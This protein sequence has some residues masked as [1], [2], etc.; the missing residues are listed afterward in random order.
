MNLISKIILKM[1]QPKCL[2]FLPSIDPKEV[3]DLLNKGFFDRS[4]ENIENKAK[5]PL[6]NAESKVNKTYSS[7]PNELIYTDNNLIIA[8]IGNKNQ[9][10]RCDFC[11]CDFD[12]QVFGVPK[13]YSR[14]SFLDE[15]NINHLR[16]FFLISGEFCSLE[17]VYAYMNKNSLKTEL[18]LILHKLMF[19]DKVLIPSNDPRLLLTNA[20]S[21]TFEEWKSKKYVYHTTGSDRSFVHFINAREERI[22]S[23]RL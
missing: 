12:T 14:E 5:I 15:D 7:D 22:R 19:P 4:V 13:Q 18:L 17:C 21:L 6:T 8:T 11:K 23:E 1:E 16:H 2:I 20:G 3:F 10:P 9:N